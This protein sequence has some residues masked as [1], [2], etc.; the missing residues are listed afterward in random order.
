MSGV[1]QNGSASP[2]LANSQDPSPP[3]KRH[4]N[5]DL[6]TR[7]ELDYAP[8][9]TVEKWQSRVTGLTVAWANFESPLLNSYATL[10][11]EIFEDSGV[12]HTLEHLIFLG[13]ELYPYKGV[14]DTLANRAFASGTN[15][16]TAN[17]H[18]A[19]TL[20]TAGSDGFLRMLP[21]YLDHVLFPT[22][23][24]AGFVTEVYHIN[25]KGEDAGVVFSEMQGRE[26]SSQDLMELKTQRML[27]PRSSA[28]RSETGGL[29][30]ALRVLTIDDIRKY[31]KSYYAPHNA[32]LVVCGP[33]DREALLD[34]LAPVEKRIVEKGIAQGPKGPRGWKR[35]F[36]E[37]TSNVPP[38]IDGSKT[39]SDGVDPADPPAPG[40]PVD[41]KRRRVFID[42][43]E[44]DESV[45]E[46]EVT[47]VGPKFGDW[48]ENEAISILGT[49]L[50]DSA[51]SA[52]QKAF[53]ERDDPLC[54]DVYM[55]TTDKAGRCTVVAYFS[56]VPTS[57]LDK[58]DEQLVELLEKVAT[59]G[60]DMQRMAMVIKR[61]RL[62]LLSQL[63]TKPA[64]S[65]SDV[66]IM[67]FLY[68][69]RDGSD[70]HEAMDDMKRYDT[71][72]KYT[73]EDWVSIL[74]KYFIENPRVVVIGKPSA[75]LVDKLKADTK[76][77]EEKRRSELGEKGLKE[78]E[79]K[80]EAA[81]KENDRDIPPEILSSFKVPSV[82]SIKWIPVGTARNEPMGKGAEEPETKA[83]VLD[84]DLDK[85]VQ[86]HVDSDGR[87]NLPYF[88]QFD[89]VTSSFVTISLLISTANLPSHLRSHLNLYL[90][91]LFSLPVTRLDG[92]GQKLTYEEV[93]KSLDED[94]L[95][96]EVSLG[97][98]SGFAE[99]ICAEVKVERENYEKA[100][101]WL[102][103][104]VWGSEFSVERLKVSA[105]KI[106]QSLPEQKRD[107]RAI[108]WALSRA[109]TQDKA[110]STNLSNSVLELVQVMPKLVETLNTNPEEVVRDFEEIRSVLMV[111]ENLRVSVAGDVL[112]LE[113][114]KGAWFD[115]FQKGFEAKPC[116]PVP[117]S[118][119]SLNE[120]GRNPSLQ[121]QIIAL[122][123]I[124][125]S[126]AVFSAK[127]I[128][129]P[130][131]PDN[132]SLVV[133]LSVLN[134]MESY[135][136]RFIRGAGLAYGASIRSDP[137]AQLIHFSLYRSP[138]SAKAFLEARKVIKSLVEGETEMDETVLESAKSSL[139]FGVADSEGTVGM[140]AMESFID[141]VV[142]GCGKNRGRRLLVD[143]SKVTISDVKESLKKYV[144]P[145]FEP[146][147]SI[148]AVVAP[149]SK[150]DEI[151]KQL[152]DVGY[153]MERKEI[154]LGKDEDDEDG[155][156]ESGSE[157]GSESEEE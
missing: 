90:S 152:E 123:T 35:P 58:L 60:I 42:F 106:V 59:E 53:I 112:G 55:G 156:S 25:G 11:T 108:S 36:V 13:S 132:P 17:D 111:P 115:N 52:I 155:S 56:S 86:A 26:N 83:L 44:K 84:T 77:L 20:T 30:S 19:Y 18:T 113:R 120:L 96:Y 69:K 116:N 128:S 105:S 99:L 85:K 37:T 82:D 119:S 95:E 143:T 149:P 148:A 93:V 133:T 135:L 121:G 124:E 109:M 134:A 12:P 39:D 140:A 14:L 104:L 101:A 50:T 97:I 15:A 139:H 38:T 21:V 49:Y 102:R 114:P 29:M 103:D 2:P 10:A 64:D 48:L 110:K 157:S 24:S 3:P 151:Q 57:Q 62:K 154:N 73:S 129:H 146:K 1:T 153:A 141:T 4:G 32:V 92:S 100:I 81:K 28:Y 72:A 150:V 8:G 131:D 130:M 89:H 88:V 61:D 46:V 78:L 98:G 9:M 31:H 87:D 125:S 79:E 142:K 22:L 5:F 65:F 117:W 107:G 47:W 70:L 33:V 67:D 91:V 136:W 137:E 80:L 43:P 144:L 68:G 75:S 34:T 23:T 27:Y 138:D 7:V 76:A 126:Y 122:P 94:T 63:E 66:I 54:T 45:G 71:L 118:R 16:W 51:V 41:A 147:T 6:I 145:I 74:R 127:G 40:R